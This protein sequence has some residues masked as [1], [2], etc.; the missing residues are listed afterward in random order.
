MQIMELKDTIKDYGKDIRL[1]LSSV[2]TEEGSPGLSQEQIWGIELA[3]AYYTKN[4]TLIESIQESAAGTLS[5]NFMEAAKAAA[6]VM[7]MNNIYYRF[8]HLVEEP[9]F[10]KMPAKLRMN[11]IGN[12]G[13]EKVGFEL[14]SLAVSALSGCG[15][16][17]NAHV[18]EIKKAG[19]ANEG[20]QSSIRIASVINATDQA[21]T[22]G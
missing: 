7:A 1:N 5:P 12:P 10:S 13:I 16:C 4:Q 19:I 18:H 9:E 14:M 21:L 3:S 11:V 6:T 20:I 8:T 22:I 17:I 15:K 2:T